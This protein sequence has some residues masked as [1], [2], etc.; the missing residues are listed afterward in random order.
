MIG[1][2]LPIGIGHR[3]HAVPAV[4]RGPVDIGAHVGG[5]HHHRANRLHHFTLVAVVIG[6]A[7]RSI[8][9][10][11]KSACTIILLARFAIGVGNA[12]EKVLRVQHF[13]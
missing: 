7:T 3:A 12:V 5:A 6:F 11:H 2:H 4:V 1:N 9:Y 13:A 10:K 8:F